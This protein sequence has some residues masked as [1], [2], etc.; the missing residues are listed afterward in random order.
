MLTV[1]EINVVNALLEEEIADSVGARSDE[2]VSSLIG[3]YLCTLS[4]IK[5]KLRLLQ[6]QYY[7]EDSDTRHYVS[8]LFHV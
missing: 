4:A 2:S 8:T 5:G 6:N 7:K 1:K 3:Q